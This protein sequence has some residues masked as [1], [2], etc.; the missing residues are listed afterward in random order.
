MIERRVGQFKK[1]RLLIFNSLL[2][3]LFLLGLIGFNVLLLF[4]TTDFWLSLAI[5]LGKYFAI[6]INIFLVIMLGGVAIPFISV[7]RKVVIYMSPKNKVKY[8]IP[9]VVE[10]ILHV[11]TEH[12]GK[13]LSRLVLVRKVNFPGTMKEFTEILNQLWKEEKIKREFQDY[14]KYSAV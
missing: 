14:P 5:E 6:P 13:S 4:S 8:S 10:K 1:K 7:W 2:F 3:F 11:L 12:K 9:E